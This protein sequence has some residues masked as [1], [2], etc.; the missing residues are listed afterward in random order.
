[1]SYLFEES[2]I[3][4]MTLKNRFVRSA[5]WEGLAAEDGGVT[6]K[7][8]A[9]MAALAEGGI[10]L[11]I[12]SHAYVSPEGQATPWQIGIYKDDLLPGLLQMTTAVHD[13]GG[14]IMAQLAHAGHQASDKITGRPALAVSDSDALTGKNIRVATTADIEE[15]V[16]AFARAAARAKAAG[17][18]GIEI[19]SGHGYLLSQF[20][21]PA[22]NKRR[23][24]YGGGIANR[25]AVHLQIY[26]AVREIVGRDYPVFIKMN[27]ADFTENGLTVDD[28]LEAAKRFAEAGFDAIE[29][30]GGIL[31]P[32][33]LTPSRPGIATAEQ[34]AYHREYAVRFKGA[35]KTPLILVGGLRSFEVAEQIIAQGDADYIAMSRPLI[36]EPDL[37]DRWQKGDMRRAACVSDNL[38]FKPGFTGKGV[39][40]VTRE[41]EALKGKG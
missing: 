11:I 27:C 9:A 12:S 19:H 7:L 32:G 14:K 29:V 41:K 25:T 22:F 24:E 17:F 34:E 23:D 16:A 37:I 38:C 2:T 3:C 39:Y 13:R 33:K 36:R 21:S 4:G 40:C 31:G 30:S 5:T 8:T 18:D 6:P 15:L 20:L 26:R 1:M 35:I 10:G 28:G